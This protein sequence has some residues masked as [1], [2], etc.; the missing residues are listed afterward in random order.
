MTAAEAIVERKKPFKDWTDFD[1][2]F[3]D[4]KDYPNSVEYY[5]KCP[6]CGQVHGSYKT[7]RDAH[8]RKTCERCSIE[9]TNKIKKQIQQVIWEP[10]K[11]VKP[12]AAI[13]RE[14]DELPVAQPDYGPDPL[15][16][17]DP[18]DEINRLLTPNWVEAAK[19]RLAYHLDEDLDSIEISKYGGDYD[20]DNP[21]DTTYFTAEI[22]SREWMVFKDSDVA[23]KVAEERVAEDV[24]NE[25]GLFT[26]SFLAQ[27]IDK[28]QLAQA[29]GDPY[30]DYGEDERNLDYN[31]KLDKMVEENKIDYDDPLFFKKNGD[32]RIENRARSAQLD[33]MVE[34]WIEET[35]P[36]VDPWEWL[37]DVYGRDHAAE[38]ALKMVSVDAEK[39]AHDVV[40]SDGWENTLA[41]YDGRSDEIG[42]E[43]FVI[44]RI[45]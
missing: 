39:V 2:V 36:T 27:Y 38:E 14:A 1:G 8:S 12:L 45:N 28:D 4:L 33:A 20:E 37:E 34:E 29:I 22:G 9:K 25:P 35:K 18:W 15:E 6:V 32:P 23:Q 17:Q 30:E 40:S 3:A 42:P 31:E 21:E 41:S 7:L 13:V 24:N 5:V 44:C 16:N 19:R 43:N 26:T 11:K 10:E